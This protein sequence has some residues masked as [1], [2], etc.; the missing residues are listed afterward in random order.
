MKYLNTTTLINL[1]NIMLSA[2]SHIKGSYC[3]ISL[4][5]KVQSKQIH[6]VR[7]RSVVACDWRWRG[8]KKAR[9]AGKDCTTSE[10]DENIL[11]LSHG[12]PM[13]IIPDL[14]NWDS[15]AAASSR[16]ALAKQTNQP[17]SNNNKMFYNWLYNSGCMK[18]HKILYCKWI[19]F[20]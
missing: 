8:G 11:K 18:N 20:I 19:N 9:E 15:R 5:W 16:L 13:P 14:R 12:S 1:D 6:T 4:T 3:A 7:S 2:E 17:N 10:G